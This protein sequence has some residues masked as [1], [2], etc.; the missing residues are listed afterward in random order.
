MLRQNFADDPSQ[1]N[2]LGGISKP[3]EFNGEVLFM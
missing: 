1:N 3:G 2:M